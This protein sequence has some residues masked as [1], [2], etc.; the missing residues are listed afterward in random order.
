MG[1]I[2]NKTSITVGFDITNNKQPIDSRFIIDDVNNIFLPSSWIRDDNTPIIPYKGLIVCDYNG[3]AMSCINDSSEVVNDNG[4]NKPTYCLKSSWKL[5]GNLTDTYDTTGSSEVA[6]SSLGAFNM[7][8]YLL[9]KITT[10]EGSISTNE[11]IL[12]M[13]AEIIALQNRCTELESL[14][15]WKDTVS[16]VPPT[17][18][19]TEEPIQA[20][21]EEAEAIQNEINLATYV[22]RNLNN[23]VSFNTMETDILSTTPTP[24]SNTTSVKQDIYT[25]MENIN[26][27]T[28]TLEDEY[29]KLENKCTFNT[30]NEVTNN[31]NQIMLRTNSEIE[32]KSTNIKDQLE[33]K[34]NIITY[35]TNKLESLLN[36]MSFN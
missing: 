14:L 8:S 15:N 21:I 30:D 13:Q 35:I 22:V 26:N 34:Q 23:R 17:P 10:L 7:Y 2:F 6:L 18:V 28:V 29:N 9:G 32:N 24:Y 33:N 25:V 4:T 20:L 16:P 19:Q 31:T 12:S 1:R 27:S 11:T 3:N 5:L 36:K